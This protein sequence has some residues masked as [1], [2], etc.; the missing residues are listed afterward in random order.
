MA[1][2]FICRGTLLTSHGAVMRADVQ[3][4]HGTSVHP[5]ARREDA[6]LCRRG[7]LD[8]PAAEAGAPILCI[9]TGEGSQHSPAGPQCPLGV[10]KPQVKMGCPARAGSRVGG[11]R[12]GRF[13]LLHQARIHSP[14]LRSGWLGRMRATDFTHFVK[15]NSI[16]IKTR[17][18]STEKG[19]RVGVGLGFSPIVGLYWA[20]VS[21]K[22]FQV[23]FKGGKGKGMSCKIWR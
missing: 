7:S 8:A 13:Q 14:G 9:S 2:A 4:V 15:G 1:G 19:G 3:I 6:G 21:A 22:S 16:P 10:T 12:K 5:R 18:I 20:N 11:S 23:R 17:L